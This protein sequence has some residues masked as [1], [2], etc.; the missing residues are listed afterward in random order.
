M[1]SNGNFFEDI[2]NGISEGLVSSF[3]SF[4]TGILL[5]LINPILT[6]IGF[7]PIAL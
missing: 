1:T 4:I 3:A 2:L 6:G 5:G 7:D